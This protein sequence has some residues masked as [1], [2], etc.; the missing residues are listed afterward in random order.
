MLPAERTISFGEHVYTGPIA[1]E[2]AKEG[3][4]IVLI[5]KALLNVKVDTQPEPLKFS[6]G[7]KAGTTGA[8]AYATML[9]EWANPAKMGKEIK[10]KGCSLEFGIVY[11][12]FF[13]T[14]VPGAIGFAGQLMLGQKE[15]KLAMKLS[16]NPKDQVLAASVTDLGVVDLVQFASKVCEIDF[17]KPPKDL[18][19]FNKF[20]LYLSTG[21]SIGEIYFPAGASLSGDMLILGKKAKFDCTVG[22]KGVKL[23]ATIEQF[24]L[25]PLKVKGATGKD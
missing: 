6:L 15:A 21:A 22:G 16:Q 19:H 2:F 11:A 24:D 18:L 7:L 25:G 3:T 13:T 9:N 8:A 4:D 17:P 10:I 5:V 1:I 12:T 14:G 20:D 23:M